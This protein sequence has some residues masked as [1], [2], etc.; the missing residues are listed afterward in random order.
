VIKTFLL[1]IALCFAFVGLSQQEQDSIVIP[2]DIATP[3][4]N[5]SYDE[6]IKN[7]YTGD[8]FNYSSAEGEAQNMMSRFLR[9][10]R[11]LFGDMFGIDIPPGTL[12]FIEYLIYALMGGL[13]IY[14][15]VKFLV[16]ENLGAIFSKKATSLIDINLSEEHIEKLDLDA[17]IKDAVDQKNYRLA[18]RYHYLGVLKH[19]SLKNIIEWQYEKTNLD[20][21]QEISN[22]TLKP[23]F[24]E[25]SYLYDYIW[26]GEQDIDAVKFSAAEGRFAALQQR[27]K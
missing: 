9:W 18:V 13:A 15:L 20:Y 11:N 6:D 25:V 23:L 16:G 8:D 22:N 7:K 12:K 3:L 4:E 17:L 2:E 24:Q 26:Y 5:R 10:F 27:I 1:T 19:L 14:L 21:Q